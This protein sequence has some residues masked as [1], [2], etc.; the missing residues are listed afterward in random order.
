M[1]RGELLTEI[2]RRLVELK[3]S[4]ATW[5]PDEREDALYLASLEVNRKL[6]LMRKTSTAATVIDKQ[7]YLLTTDFAITAGTFAGLVRPGLI[8][9]DGTQDSDPL[10]LRSVEWLYEHFPNW[11]NDSSGTPRFFF[12]KDGG[13]VFNDTLSLYPKTDKAVAGGLR[14]HHLLRPA[15][16]TLDDHQPF[17]ATAGITVQFPSLE[18][19]HYALVWYSCYLLLQDDD[20]KKAE[21]ALAQYRGVV[22]GAKGEV[23]APDAMAHSAPGIAVVTGYRHGRNW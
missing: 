21:I 11:R 7:D 15:R 14:L 16:M 6:R 2:G 9:Y 19:F 5:E 18:P 4:E 12:P 23:F 22:A 13:L 10:T 8:Y 20:A 17:N 1:T 3:G